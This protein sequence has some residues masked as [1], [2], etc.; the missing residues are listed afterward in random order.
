LPARNKITQARLPGVY[1][2][3]QS[4]QEADVM[5]VELQHLARFQPFLWTRDDLPGCYQYPGNLP[6]HYMQKHGAG[7][8]I[9]ARAG[10]HVIQE[11]FCKPLLKPLLLLYHHKPSILAR[12]LKWPKVMCAPDCSHLPSIYPWPY[13]WPLLYGRPLH[14]C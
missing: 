2:K 6:V 13:P 12:W 1:Q 9:P 4:A 5:P 7:H 8:T 14:G 3:L 11:A 10:Q